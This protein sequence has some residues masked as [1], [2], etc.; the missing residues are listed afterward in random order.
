[1]Y[2]YV[3]RKCLG[4]PI[5]GVTARDFKIMMHFCNEVVNSPDSDKMPDY[6][7]FHLGLHCFAKE[8]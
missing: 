4:F 3:D 1:M 8:G 2:M 5:K 7:A 6:A